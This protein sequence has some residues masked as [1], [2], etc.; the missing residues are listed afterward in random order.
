[1]DAKT[2]LTEAEMRA[3]RIVA[4]VRLAVSVLGGLL[5][6][7]AVL[8]TPLGSQT[9]L[10]AQIPFV[11]VFFAGYFAVGLMSFGLARPERF[12][13]WMPWAFTTCDLGFWFVNLAAVVDNVGLPSNQIFLS[14]PIW[15]APFVLALAALHYNTWL[16]VYATAFVVLSLITIVFVAPWGPAGAARL[17]GDLNFLLDPRANALRL[18]VL[19]FAGVVLIVAVVGARGLLNRAI[20]ETVRR[21]NLTRYLPPQLADRMADAGEDAL[22]AG[23]EQDAAILFVD[24]RGFTARAEGMDPKSL[25]RFLAAFRHVITKTAD[26]W[27]GVVDKFVGDSAMVVFGVPEPGL[28]DA[29]KALACAGAILDALGAW[30]AERGA[31]GDDAVRVG[32]GVHWGPVF[33]GAV[34]NTDRLEFTVLGD[35]VN[36]ASRLEA[37]TKRAGY[38]LIASAALLAAAGVDPSDGVWVE[39]PETAIRGHQGNVR[40]Y[41]KA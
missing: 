32:I 1:M 39:I 5:F 36:V 16:Q 37:E 30:N 19:V 15:I 9:R 7:A 29:A 22:R 8:R 33:C 6:Y 25:N 18:S 27:D 12:R 28:H 4:L 40:H 21:A 26:R 17:E 10:A 13:A 31:T 14:P 38:P 34:G 11:L 24:I 2:L 20:A 23:R 41:G 35:T 3:E